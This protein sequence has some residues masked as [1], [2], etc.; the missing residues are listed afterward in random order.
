MLVKQVENQFKDQIEKEHKQNNEL[1]NR[2]MKITKDNETAQK[3]HDLQLSKLQ[4]ELN[5]LAKQNAD[6]SEQNAKQA[7][8]FNQ[9][10]QKMQDSYEARLNE[11]KGCASGCMG[12][13][14]ACVSVGG[15][16]CWLVGIIV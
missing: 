9:N 14:A 7:Q 11:R 10:L 2:L 5:K 15:L 16:I 1:Q 3:N 8:E 12:M 4:G 6:L 13:V